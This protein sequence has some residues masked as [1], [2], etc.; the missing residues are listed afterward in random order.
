[1][2]GVVSVYEL[3][4]G[5]RF[6]SEVLRHH[7]RGKEISQMLAM[8]IAEAQAFF[9]ERSVRLMLD[10]LVDVG[11]SYI[12]L[13]Q[14]LSAL[15]AGE[16]QRRKLAIEWPNRPMSSCWTS[17]PPACTWRTSTDSLP[18]RPSRR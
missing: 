16:R 13:G 7:L 3:C 10:G 15:S 1:M 9:S 5:R 18:P 12:S 8:S 4:E 14:P 11:L 2:A 17:Q 6:T